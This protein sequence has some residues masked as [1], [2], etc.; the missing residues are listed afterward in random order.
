MFREFREE[1]LGGTASRVAGGFLDFPIRGDPMTKGEPCVPRLA[2][3]VSRGQKPSYISRGVY[4]VV[5][6]APAD[7]RAPSKL[8]AV[9]GGLVDLSK[10]RAHEGRP[11]EF[12]HG[13]PIAEFRSPAWSTAA[14]AAN[15]VPDCN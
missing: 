15:R 10:R 13:S 5:G 3:G 11:S 2:R 4:L 7:R 1:P 14:E 9:E 12:A 6:A 8:R